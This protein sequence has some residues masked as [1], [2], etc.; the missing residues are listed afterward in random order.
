MPYTKLGSVKLIK[1]EDATEENRQPHFR[2]SIEI[3][4]NIPA[5]A[6]INI[7]G[8]YNPKQNN[9]F[10]ALSAH[11]EQ[12]A[13]ETYDH[14]MDLE[15]VKELFKLRDEGLTLEEAISKVKED[16]LPF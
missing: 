1:N 9:M 15:Q 4:K 2:G 8:W 7:A 12:L 13:K 5:T 6:R 10:F 16:D 3:P 14:E 11:D